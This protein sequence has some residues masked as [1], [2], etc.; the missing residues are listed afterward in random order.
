MQCNLRDVGVAGACIN[1][2]AQLVSDNTALWKN[3]IEL[4]A[5]FSAPARIRQYSAHSTPFRS[6][7]LTLQAERLSVKLSEQTAHLMAGCGRLSGFSLGATTRSR[8]VPLT[9]TEGDKSMFVT[10]RRI[11][12][13]SAALGIVG[14]SVAPV[15]AATEKTIQQTPFQQSVQAGSCYDTLYCFITFPAATVQTAIHSVSC[16]S[17]VSAG[18][19]VQ[20]L[21]LGVT[22]PD[23]STASVLL[24]VFS[25]G[26]NGQGLTTGSNLQTLVFVQTGVTP[27]IFFQLDSGSLTYMNCTISG[28]TLEEKK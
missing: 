24:P 25:Q 9:R 27:T 26:P 6:S 28:W 20:Q 22:N 23:G 18:A 5:Y 19:V 4:I 15:Q 21:S 8:V 12:L 10:M 1:R 13:I 11:A 3:R 7:S 17:V 14:F 16:W 2:I